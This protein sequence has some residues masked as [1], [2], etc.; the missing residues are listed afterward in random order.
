MRDPNQLALP[1]TLLM[2][3]K[4]ERQKREALQLLLHRFGDLPIRMLDA[5][6]IDLEV[7]INEVDTKPF[8]TD[9]YFLYLRDL[10]CWSSTQIEGLIKFLQQ[11]LPKW[12]SLVFSAVSI[13]ALAP[14]SQWLESRGV[15]LHMAEEKPWQK[16]KAM[17]AWVQREA[18]QAGKRLGWG[19][20]Q[21]LVKRVG[22]DEGIVQ[23]ELQKLFLYVGERQEVTLADIAAVCVRRGQ[24]SLWELGE[25]LFS[26]QKGEAMRIA[27]EL[28]EEGQSVHALL[29]HLRMQLRT[30]FHMALLFG[31][32]GYPAVNKAFPF[33]KGNLLKEK[34]ERVQ[35][36]G[37]E[38][39]RRGLVRIQQTEL[40]AKSSGVDPEI[41]LE[42]LIVVLSS[43]EDYS[44]MS[45]ATLS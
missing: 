3:S 20:A 24:E 17:V 21:E 34:V 14:F 22:L 36:Y 12:V 5:T 25:A 1:M 39:F 15:V 8:F 29:A 27:K 45:S 35:G 10:E 16:E 18:V 40:Q 7:L 43:S 26:L 41:L 42:V 28:V 2:L 38:R 37:V 13:P 23:S 4:E 6:R 11:P 33:L 44:M 31:K 30:G 9:H 19:H 32:G